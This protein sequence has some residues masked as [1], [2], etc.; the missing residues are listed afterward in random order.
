MDPAR[1]T[2]P[3]NPNGVPS[4]VDV[5]VQNPRRRILMAEKTETWHDGWTRRRLLTR[6][7]TAPLQPADRDS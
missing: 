6:S 7:R 2:L 3:T 5:Y 1:S 4:R